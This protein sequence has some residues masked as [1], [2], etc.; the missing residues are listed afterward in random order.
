MYKR[1][2][3]YVL[4]SLP[5]SHLGMYMRSPGCSSSTAIGSPRSAAAGL[6]FRSGLGAATISSYKIHVF[7]P[8]S[9]T[10]IP[11]KYRSPFR[12]GQVSRRSESSVYDVDHSL[13]KRLIVHTNASLYIHSENFPINSQAIEVRVVLAFYQ[14]RVCKS[15]KFQRI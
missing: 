4:V 1:Q 8:D 3:V 5:L 10:T 7:D 13:T 11:I 12:C 9:C 15:R 2:P 14:Y 6:N